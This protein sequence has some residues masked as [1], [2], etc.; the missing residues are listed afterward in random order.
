MSPEA[1]R[2]AIA[3]A[4]GWRVCNGYLIHPE[5]GTTSEQ[6]ASLRGIGAVTVERW[7]SAAMRTPYQEGIPDYVNDLNEIRNV[8]KLLTTE[9]KCGAYAGKLAG[10]CEGGPD[11]PWRSV[12]NHIWHASAAQ[13]AEALLMT[14][15]LWKEAK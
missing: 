11:H 9:A 14:L 10:I 8:E 3:E 13:R 12:R 5:G 2:I 1:Q 15:N 7:L 6:V 4:L